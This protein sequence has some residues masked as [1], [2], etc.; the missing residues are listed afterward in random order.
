MD[1]LS[2]EMAMAMMGTAHFPTNAQDLQ[3]WDLDLQKD[4][5]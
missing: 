1:L 3:V 4:Q 2:M 5:C